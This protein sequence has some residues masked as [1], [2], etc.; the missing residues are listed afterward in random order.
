MS[1]HDERSLVTVFDVEADQTSSVTKSWIQQRIEQYQN[2][3]DVF[4][5]AFIR[6][7]IFYGGQRNALE[8]TAGAKS[9]LHEM[10]MQCYDHIPVTAQVTLLPG[11]Y[12]LLDGY[13]RDVWR[14]Y[15]DT[16][17]AFIST[18]KPYKNG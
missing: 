12:V 18:V 14:L 17:G 9:L 11:P 6:G 10:G 4:Q 8:L 2:T 16:N 7:V 5:I 13:L 15:S 3:D 1:G